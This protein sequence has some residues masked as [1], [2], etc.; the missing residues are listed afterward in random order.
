M[1]KARR[2]KQ[3]TSEEVKQLASNPFT[4]RVSACQIS[5]TLEFKLE[6]KNLFLARYEAGESVREIFQSLGYDTEILGESRIYC[7]AHQ[8]VKRAEE[9]Q[10][11]REGPPSRRERKP[12]DIDYNTMPS[13]QSIAAM[14]R[15]IAYLR[16]HLRNMDPVRYC[17]Q[18]LPISLAA[19]NSFTFPSF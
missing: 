17:L 7:F 8:L 4:Y 2:N 13:Q 11:M 10:L 9:G 16:Q 18:I 14:Q 1:W 15:E 5:Y 6:F 12:T 3:F 19:A